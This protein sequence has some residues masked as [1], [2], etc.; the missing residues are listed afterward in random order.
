MKKFLKIIFGIKFYMFRTV[1]VSIIRSLATVH[2]EI[3][4]GHTEI[5]SI[6]QISAWSIPTAVCTVLDY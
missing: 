3:G 1:S 4:I 5:V 6:V 2:T